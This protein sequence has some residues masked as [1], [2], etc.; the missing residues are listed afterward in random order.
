M[1]SQILKHAT[2]PSA[3]CVAI[4]TT[5]AAACDGVGDGDDHSCDGKRARSARVGGHARGIGAGAGRRSIPHQERRVE[6]G[7]VEDGAVR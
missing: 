7:A 1:I 2:P 6:N 5:A 4:D 3:K